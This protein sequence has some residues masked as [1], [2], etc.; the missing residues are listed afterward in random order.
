MTPNPMMGAYI[1]IGVGVLFAL[2]MII[3]IPRQIRKAKAHGKQAGDKMISDM[4]SRT[5]LK[6]D[7]AAFSGNY[8]GYTIR[9][10]KGLGKN[11]AKTFDGVVDILTDAKYKENMSTNTMIYPTLKVWL[12]KPGAN[13]PDVTLFETGNFFLKNDEFWNNR[14][15]GRIPEDSKLD[16]DADPLHKKGTFYGSADGA[17]KMLD[18]SELK[19]L[20]STWIYPDLRADKSQI[21][22][23][24][25]NP[26]IIPKWGHPKTTAID[27]M[28]QGADI[29]V[30]TARALES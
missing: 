16:I 11:A 24:L 19:Q 4:E 17:R 9:M 27:W 5:G 14:V 18:S 20:M 6:W 2:I 28:I 13:F 23:E 15:N 3:V 8:K 21:T 25:N 26:S 12:E 10:V 30:A 7:G 1:G 29:C 22:L